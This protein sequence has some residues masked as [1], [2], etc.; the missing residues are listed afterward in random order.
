MA[1]ELFRREGEGG[2]EMIEIDG[3]LLADAPVRELPMACEITIDAPSTLPEFLAPTQSVVQQL[4]SDLAGRIA[5][6]GRTANR[7][8]IL[9]YLPDDEQAERFTR[10]P[11]PAKASVT[12]APAND[13]DWTLFE[14][15]RPRDM[16]TQSMAD[17]AVMAE[18]HAAGD[19]GGEREIEHT[20]TDIA[21]DRLE[22]F[23]EA[24]A[25]LGFVAGEP[26][27]DEVVLR[28]RADPSDLTADSWTL[29]LVAERHGGTYGGWRCDLVLPEPKPARRWFGR[30]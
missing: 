15:L 13:P 9:T 3:E 5:A 1:W 16:E 23:V 11:L 19:V 18:L 24:A 20:I 22:E 30:R 14:R 10:I 4:A 8:S 28:H 12:V 27:A 21:D 17:L 29:R 6:T 2:L 25:R 26:R 7:L